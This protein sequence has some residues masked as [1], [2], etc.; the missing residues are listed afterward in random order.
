[1]ASRSSSVIKRPTKVKVGPLT[2]D[3][4]WLNEDEWYAQRYEEETIGLCE[5]DKCLI[6]IRA[7]TTAAED[8]LRLTLLHEILHTTTEEGRITPFIK[9]V[10]D[11]EEFVVRL[12][13]PVLLGILNDNPN[14]VAYL[15]NLG[16]PG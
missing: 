11:A 10:D 7:D 16:Q 1:M 5:R 13:A 3:V 6:S 15:L 2:Y 4:R 14:V 8:A 12:M 9:E